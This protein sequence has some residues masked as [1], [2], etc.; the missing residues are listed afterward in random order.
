MDYFWVMKWQQRF[1]LIAKL[2][3]SGFHNY[4]LSNTHNKHLRST[5]IKLMGKNGHP[6][7]DISMD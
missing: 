7:F 4:E 1:Y 5:N 2:T 3:G 6:I